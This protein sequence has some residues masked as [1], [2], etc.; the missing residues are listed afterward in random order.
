MLMVRRTLQMIGN[1]RKRVADFTAALTVMKSIMTGFRV[2]E[3]RFTMAITSEQMP[4]QTRS[5]PAM[6]WIR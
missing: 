1:R 3:H 6:T 4:H 2:S 5:E